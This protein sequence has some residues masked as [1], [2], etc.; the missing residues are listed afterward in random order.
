MPVVLF[1]APAPDCCTLFTPRRPSV[2]AELEEV[3]RL[4]EKIDFNPLVEE[5][6]EGVES[7]VL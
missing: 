2:R 7:T 3:Q 5:A 1:Q 6:F 4:E